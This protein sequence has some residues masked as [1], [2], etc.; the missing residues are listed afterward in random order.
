ME[1]S[2]IIVFSTAYHPFTGGAE[3]AIQ[4][5]LRRLQDRFDPRT[6]RPNELGEASG[7]LCGASPSART[8]KSSGNTRESS[9]PCSGLRF[10][11]VTSRFRRDLPKI[12][13]RPEGTVIRLGLGTRFDKWFLPFLGFFSARRIIRSNVNGQTSNV[14]MWAVD[15]GQGS[16]AAAVFKL[17]HPRIPLI[18][19]LQY[20]YGAGRVVGGRLGLIG[21]AFRF[22]LRRADYVTAIS[23]YLLNLAKNHGYRGSGSIVHN[24]VDIEKFTPS[25]D[26]VPRR[27]TG[28]N[29]NSKTVITV[30]RLVPKNGIDT[31][32]SAIVEVKKS[33]P[34][35]RC[36]ILGEG[37]EKESLKSQVKS[38][39]LDEN[40]EF[41]GNVPYDEISKYL[42]EA[43]V[44]VRASRSEGMGNAFVEALAAGVPIIGTPVEGIL[45]IIQDGKTGFFARVDDPN[46]LAQKIVYV[47]QNE[48]ESE[49]SVTEGRRMVEEKFSWNGIAQKYRFIFDRYYRGE[50]SI[51]SIEVSPLRIVIATPLYPPQLGGPAIYAKNL[52]EE[53]S[54]LRHQV[55]IVSFGKF[56]RL[57]SLVRH[58]LYFFKVFRSSIGADI[59]F[60]LDYFSV[61]APAALAALLLCKPLVIR[62]EGDF[63]W[64]SYVERRRSDTTLSMFYPARSQPR[65][66]VGAAVPPVAERTSNG[67]YRNL[68]RLSA[69]ERVIHFIS[70]WVLGRSRI[71]VFSSEWRREMVVGSRGHLRKKSIIIGNVWPPLLENLSAV[72]QGSRV[73]LWAGRMLY[74]KN[75]YR[76]LRAFSRLKSDYELHLV[77]DGPEAERLKNFVTQERIKKVFF[78]PK[79]PHEALLKKMREAAFFVLPSLSEVG[80]NVIADAASSGTP[81]IMTRESG[82]AEYAKDFG[83]F[84]D[85][86]NENEL[87]QKLG[88]LMEETA[89]Y[90]IRKGIIKFYSAYTWGE[91]AQ[92]WIQ[93]F[94][95]VL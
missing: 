71:L 78:F 34:Q 83:I 17:F 49:Q 52:G 46:D 56:L 64:E 10:Y 82:Y 11:I 87:T 4:E 30:S 21:V 81:F 59:I 55:S 18:L 44:F 19:T 94:S 57:P 12:E 25:F 37:P 36:H 3:I 38:L 43:D 58:F 27:M 92:E 48:K 45:D 65:R 20:G 85:P 8:P 77:G 70:R 5:V 2:K 41:F 53:F 29:P 80:P 1:K 28:Q 86:L 26:R 9:S 16:L 54:R 63:L 23:I 15:I 39:K 90:N 76:L 62:V 84:V 33:I 68:P 42:H 61:G 69:K 91:A 47:L 75:L 67:A 66:D 31:L 32:I 13:E 74:L 60:A 14:V 51:V 89:R 24:G 72:S 73:I 22:M 6:E 93:V 88:M 95:K 7:L 40:V 50:T 35:I 79:L